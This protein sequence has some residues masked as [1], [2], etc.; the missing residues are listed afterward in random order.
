MSTMQRIPVPDPVL[1]GFDA[2]R[3]S[4]SLLVL[5]LG[6]IL[7]LTGFALQAGV[8][9]AM[10]AVWGGALVL[11]GATVYVFIRWSYR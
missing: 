9:A 8:W 3:S 5:T 6:S 2:L 7:F 10:L 4:A 11:L 1:D